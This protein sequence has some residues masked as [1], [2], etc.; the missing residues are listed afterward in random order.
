MIA[1][2][3]TVPNFELP[4]IEQ[5]IEIKLEDIKNAK[6]V[7]FGKDVYLNDDALVFAVEKGFLKPNE[8]QKEQL[9]IAKKEEAE[10]QNKYE[11][12]YILKKLGLDKKQVNVLFEHFR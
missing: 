9:N 12:E 5:K 4:Q 7:S 8:Q 2:I 3:D 6:F 11:L 1:T 10:E